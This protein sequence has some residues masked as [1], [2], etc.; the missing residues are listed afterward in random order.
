M[1]FFLLFLWKTVCSLIGIKALSKTF[2]RIDDD[3]EYQVIPDHVNE[4]NNQ[5]LSH[6]S[7][8]S[9]GSSVG[10]RSRGSDTLRQHPNSPWGHTS[11][12]WEKGSSVNHRETTPH[13]SENHNGFHQN[14]SGG[15]PSHTNTQ[16]SNSSKFSLRSGNQSHPPLGVPP[17]R[18]SISPQQVSS[19]S[20]CSSS[21]NRINQN[22]YY[23][24]VPES[25]N[26]SLS[27]RDSELMSYSQQSRHN[28][29][30]FSSFKS[31]ASNEVYPPVFSTSP[32][33]PSP[34]L[35]NTHHTS[36]FSNG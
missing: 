30:N 21:N 9:T 8:A 32:N 23:S 19:S 2:F 26:F 31:S 12:P 29:K 34:S 22:A 25:Q 7:K 13:G 20:N 27:N 33:A 6:S 18:Y 3:H 17:I 28:G 14:C 4:Y 24:S 10:A 11:N 15:S 5:A 36:S 1:L 35:G 16:A